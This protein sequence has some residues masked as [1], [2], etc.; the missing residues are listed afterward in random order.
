MAKQGRPGARRTNKKGAVKG[1]GGQVRRG[2]RGKGPTPRR[3]TAS[4]TPPT[5]VRRP[6]SAAPPDVTSRRTRTSSSSAATPSSSASTR[7]CPARCCTYAEGTGADDR[8]SEAVQMATTRGIPI[9]EVPRFELDKMTGNGLHQ[10]IGLQILPYKYTDVHTHRDV[11]ATGIRGC[12]SSSTTSPTHVTSAP[13]SA[14]S[15]PSGAMAWSSRAS[16]RGRHRRHLAHLRR[17]RRPRL[18]VARKSTSPAPS[19]SFSATVTRSSDST[20]G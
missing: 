7:R 20:P 17:H 4:T 18:P 16:F 11:A 8:L 3:R 10:G 15:P 1:S 13:S 2:L 5:S 12:S 6:P 14:P 9:Q 19:R